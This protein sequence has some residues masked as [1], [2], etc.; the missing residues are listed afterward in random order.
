MGISHLEEDM[1]VH[2]LLSDT[3]SMFNIAIDLKFQGEI[4]LDILERSVNDVIASSAV[5]RSRFKEVDG[6]L[7]R[8]VS[9]ART[10]LE[11]VRRYLE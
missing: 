3:R 2:H 6:S 11:R 8:Q 7:I 10:P 1:L 9:A 4:S 5:F